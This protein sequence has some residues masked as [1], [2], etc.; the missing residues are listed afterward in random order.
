[1]PAES[2]SND[3]TAEGG[4]RVFRPGIAVV[5]WSLPFVHCFLPSLLAPFDLAVFGTIINLNDGET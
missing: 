2:L 4:K 3:I 1:M 5:I